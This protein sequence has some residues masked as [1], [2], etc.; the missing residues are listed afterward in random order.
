MDEAK[1]GQAD[2]SNGAPRRSAFEHTKRSLEKGNCLLDGAQAKISLHRHSQYGSNIM[3][4]INIL[5]IALIAIYTYNTFIYIYIQYIDFMFSSSPKQDPR[6]T[7][8]GKKKMK[9]VNP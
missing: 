6:Y 2:W 8:S 5:N 7:G 4:E 1:K 3:W 9:K